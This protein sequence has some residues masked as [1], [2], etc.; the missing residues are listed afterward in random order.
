MPKDKTIIEVVLE[1]DHE[2]GVI[3]FHCTDEKK[4]ETFGVTPLRICSLPKPI[5]ERA[6]DITHGY[7]CDW[8]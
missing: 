2:R 6:L 8:R 4:M 7:G 3:Y 5:P 1:I